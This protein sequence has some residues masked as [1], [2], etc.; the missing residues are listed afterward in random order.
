MLLSIEMI[1]RIS[2]EISGITG[3]P[4]EPCEIN[5][6]GFSGRGFRIS[7]FPR[8][9]GLQ[10]GLTRTMTMSL[11]EVYPEYSAGALVR[12][13][14][15]SA[16]DNPE[17][18]YSAVNCDDEKISVTTHINDE[19]HD[20]ADELPD[21][22]WSS[23]S[24]EF[25]KIEARS[26]KELI[27]RDMIEIGAVAVS[28]TLACLF[29]SDSGLGSHDEDVAGLPEG[30][31]VKVTANRYE[32]N[33]LNRQRCISHY[34]DSCWVCEMNFGAVY[35]PPGSGY[36]EVHHRVPVSQMGGRYRVDPV[37]DLIPLCSNCHSAA[38]LRNPPFTP[39]EVRALMKLDAKELPACS[40]ELQASRTNY[41]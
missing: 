20:P 18:W 8:G 6:S 9:K 7:T 12:S 27:T 2:L 32:R 15:R 38:H 40:T 25:V 28:A 26:S 36:I 24:L 22:R 21:E 5:T 41:M 19:L 1:E 4:L 30:A 39:N 23:F 31:A 11:A 3:L 29:E 16:L 14:G 33:P 37:R 13:I 35:G 10:I 17:L 34:G